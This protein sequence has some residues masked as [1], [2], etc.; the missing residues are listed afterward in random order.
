[1]IPEMKNNAITE[2]KYIKRLKI[3][4][5]Q[6]FLLT[7]HVEEVAV[8]EDSNSTFLKPQVEQ[9]DWYMLWFYHKYINKLNDANT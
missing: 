9:C 1:M 4:L 7:Q 5:C 3:P 8:E 2:V 6:S